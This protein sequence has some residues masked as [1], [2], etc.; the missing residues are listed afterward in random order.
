MM[1]TWKG[2]YRYDNKTAQKRIGADL[3]HFTIVIHSFDGKNFKGTV[4]DD[5]SSGGMEGEGQII[6]K[7]E[8]NEVTFRKLMQK[9][10]YVYKDGTRK[11]LNKKHPTIYYTGIISADKLHMEGNWKFKWQIMF[12]F[13]LI[14][15]PVKPFPGTWSMTLQ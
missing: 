7:V 8:N 6:G 1:G 15:F 3:T 12:L 5:L 4:N 9:S 2:Y 11:T 13:G 14:P 10:T